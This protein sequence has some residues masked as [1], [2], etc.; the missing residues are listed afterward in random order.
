MWQKS[1]TLLEFD[2]ISGDSA[3][4]VTMAGHENYIT[5]NFRPND[6]SCSSVVRVLEKALTSRFALPIIRPKDRS[7]TRIK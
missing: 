5:Y 6:L 2:V 1:L 7:S 4:N 3:S